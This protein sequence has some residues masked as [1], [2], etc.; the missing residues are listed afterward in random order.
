MVNV[1]LLKI[2]SECN[3]YKLLKS[4]RG[5]LR[6]STRAAFKFLI[7]YFYMILK[8]LKLITMNLADIL[9]IGILI[10]AG[11][12]FALFSF[13][14]QFYMH[15]AIGLQGQ[16]DTSS[17]R[18][19]NLIFFLFFIISIFG[20]IKYFSWNQILNNSGIST[21]KDTP[22]NKQ[23]DIDQ[24]VTYKVQ[25][26][27]KVHYAEDNSYLN[28]SP[29]EDRVTT[30]D[31]LEVRRYNSYKEVTVKTSPSYLLQISASEIEKFALSYASKTKDKFSTQNIYTYWDNKSRRI[32]VLVGNFDSTSEAEIFKKTINRKLGI[33]SILID[34]QTIDKE[35]L[36]EINN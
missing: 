28:K 13:F 4:K 34:L 10:G 7:D 12:I 36:Q 19:N 5:I 1:F 14:R 30:N 35:H 15:P 25:D 33:N 23:K 20:L 6:C 26:V 16:V 22:S 3:Y 18:S 17:S 21:Q 8:S 9:M 27:K 29:V 2:N 31:A 24:F 32:K 11:I